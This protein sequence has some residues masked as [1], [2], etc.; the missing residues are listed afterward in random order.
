MPY[1]PAILASELK[2][3]VTNPRVS[4]YMQIAFKVIKNKINKIPAAVHKDNSS[5]FQ[6]VSKR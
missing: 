1:A 6:T 2:N 3:W 5:R 4:P